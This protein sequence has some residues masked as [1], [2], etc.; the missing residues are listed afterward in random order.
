MKFSVI[1][2]GSRGFDDYEL[3]KE[4]MD[5]YIGDISTDVEIVSGG[6]KGA[7]LLGER[8]AKERG[9]AIKQ[10]IPDWDGKGKSAGH[11]RNYDMAQYAQAC[12]VFWDGESKG[13]H[14]MYKTAQK[15][16][17]STRLVP[18]KRVLGV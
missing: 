16:G 8:Y 7:D 3:L 17:L 10:F 15:K 6:A 5:R 2:A 13:S 4:R 9:F 1:I 11:I 12:V 14:N 18:Y